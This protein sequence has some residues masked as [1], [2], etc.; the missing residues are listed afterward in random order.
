MLRKKLMLLLLLLT[1][2]V[3]VSTAERVS[4]CSGDDCGCGYAAQ[5]CDEGCPTEPGQAR[6]QCIVA[7]ARAQVRCGIACCS[8]VGGPR[9]F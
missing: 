6:N 7:C 4:A 3:S 1:L 5:A 9:V 8:Y 2:L